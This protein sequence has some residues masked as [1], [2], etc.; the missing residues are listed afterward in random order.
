MAI[1]I[2]GQANAYIGIPEKFI[3]GQAQGVKGLMLI[4]TWI[5]EYGEE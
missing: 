5:N 1:H 2:L 4:K 3:L